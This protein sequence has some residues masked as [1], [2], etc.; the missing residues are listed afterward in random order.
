M[1]ERREKGQQNTHTQRLKSVTVMHRLAAIAFD[2]V[3]T[4]RLSAHQFKTEVSVCV[5]PQSV[6]L[7]SSSPRSEDAINHVII[8]F[9]HS[10]SLTFRSLSKYL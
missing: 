8:K 10:H 6:F 3:M 4:L 5:S 9:F 7:S 2:L 1:K